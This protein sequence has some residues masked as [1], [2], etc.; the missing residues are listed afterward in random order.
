[1]MAD[2][3]S[4]LVQ[5]SAAGDAGATDEL[6]SALY[7]E[8]RKLAAQALRSERPAHT[9][10]P[11]ALVHEAYLRL[12]SNR[13]LEANDRAH[14][15]AIA[16]RVMRHVLVDHARSRNAAK[17]GAG[18]LVVAIDEALLVAARQDVDLVRVGDAMARLERDDPTLAR[19]VDLRYFGGF[20]V[21]EVAE[22]LGLSRATVERE[23]TAARVWLRKEV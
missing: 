6:F 9:L 8:M 3:M 21:E 14:F 18:T 1:M 7:G 13:M 15:L 5:R 16:A 19:I 10:Q 11:T 23:W 20:T 4:E 12:C 22:E 2:G 17:R